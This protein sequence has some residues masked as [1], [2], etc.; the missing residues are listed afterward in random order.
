MALLENK[1]GHRGMQ[2]STFRMVRF[3]MKTRD[4]KQV[5]VTLCD[6]S[7]HE[8]GKISQI[9]TNYVNEEN[10][11]SS[12]HLVCVAT[13]Y[14][15]AVCFTLPSSLVNTFMDM[16]WKSNTVGLPVHGDHP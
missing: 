7:F 11:T 16:G 10:R 12:I 13:V 9:I 6:M 2:T 4:Q 5:Q 3:Q 8:D 1:Q 15:K 14:G